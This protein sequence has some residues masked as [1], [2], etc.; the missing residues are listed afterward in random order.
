MIQ[1]SLHRSGSAGQIMEWFESDPS[2]I[3]SRCCLFLDVDGTLI[4]F[5]ADPSSAVA[6]AELRTLLQKASDKFAGALAL[7][8]GRLLATLDAML[9]PLRLPTSGLYGLE[10]RDT[11]GVVHRKMVSIDALEAARRTIAGFAAAHAGLLVEDKG[12]AIALHYRQAPSC[13]AECRRVVYAAAAEL[14]SLFQVIEG[15]MVVEIVPAEA[16]KAIAIEEF[17][18]EPPFAGRIP[19]ALGD[20]LSD[21]EAFAAVHRHQGLALAVGRRIYGDHCLENWQAARHWLSVLVGLKPR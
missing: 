2:Q 18:L 12:T 11:H 7:V 20:D 19:I 15:S 4:G 13:G 21:R 5:R 10:R 16:S 3:T 6:D 14:W 17:L 8:S 1:P 9:D